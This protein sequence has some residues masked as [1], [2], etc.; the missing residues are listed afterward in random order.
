M[1]AGRA[2]RALYDLYTSP[3]YTSPPLTGQHAKRHASCKPRRPLPA[4]VPYKIR[5]PSPVV[6]A[7]DNARCPPFSSLA[8]RHAHRYRR[9]AQASTSSSTNP[10]RIFPCRTASPLLVSRLPR[11]THCLHTARFPGLCGV[12]PHH[13]TLR[14]DP[15]PCIRISR[16]RCGMMHHIRVLHN[17]GNP[18]LAHAR[19]LCPRRLLARGG[20]IPPRSSSPLGAITIG[21]L[22]SVSNFQFSL[23]GYAGRSR[24]RPACVRDA[25][26]HGPCTGILK[27]GLSPC[28]H[29]RRTQIEI[30]GPHRLPP[31]APP[32][33]RCP[34]SRPPP[35][36]L[37][38]RLPPRPACCPPPAARRPP[39]AARRPPPAAPP[40]RCLF[41]STALQ[42]RLPVALR[43][44]LPRLPAAPAQGDS[45]A[46]Q[47]AE[48]QM[49]SRDATNTHHKP[50]CITAVAR[51]ITRRH[52]RHPALAATL[53]RCCKIPASCA[54]PL[55][56]HRMRAPAGRASPLFAI[57]SLKQHGQ[58][59]SRSHADLHSQPSRPP[60]QLFK[61]LGRAAV[62]NRLVPPAPPIR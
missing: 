4:P 15:P 5:R 37:P 8:A 48:S 43:H 47:L 62:P 9:P 39:P 2:S 32:P 13:I 56:A 29:Q 10:L 23:L 18:L 49:F 7:Q 1:C 53:P 25:A 61:C 50:P 22:V 40:A 31:A 38:P 19:S 3:L 14:R 52:A 26:S 51:P 55:P 35:A 46:G 21:H 28:S 57:T 60:P 24:Q 59:P 11:A 20:A 6:Y 54:R 44:P 17:L 27:I 36:R 30:H 12:S 45:V 41:C 58:R 33:S 42:P 16:E 34:A